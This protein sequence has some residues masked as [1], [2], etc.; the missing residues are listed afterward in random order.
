MADKLISN[1]SD[2]ARWVAAYRASESA[3][4]DALFQDRFA[5]RLAGEH[6]KEIATRGSN[7]GGT[8]NGWPIVTRTKLIDDLVY[9]SIEQGCDCVLNLAAGLDSRPYRLALPPSLRWVEVDLPGILD[10]KERI[11]ASERP[12]CQ[13][14]RE[15]V[16]LADVSARS[17][18][19]EEIDRSA[20][21]VLVITEGLLL[22]LE[23]DAVR[24]LG[25]D[26][27]RHRTFQWWMSDLLSPRVAA[28][29]R[30]NMGAELDNA[31][32]K[33]AP[34]NG[35]AFFE[36]LGW[37]VREVKSLFREGV[38]FARV[39]WYLRPFARFPEADAR[40]PGDERWSAV[41]RFRRRS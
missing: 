28:L 10:E 29:M 4:P 22:Y 34:R 19:F 8:R 5:E 7:R 14:R 35:I 23:P 3:R 1:V 32:L 9:E 31:P 37:E 40:R 33:F 36:P 27:A 17:R 26:L 12:V 2:T 41:V 16:D 25:K 13:L 6:G 21:R 11:L 18:L 38:R 20:T 30:T 15:P 24:D 39:P